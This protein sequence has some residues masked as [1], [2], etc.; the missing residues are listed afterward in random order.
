MPR[1]KK[2]MKEVEVLI[3]QYCRHVKKQWLK[4]SN[5]MYYHYRCFLGSSVKLSS[6]NFHTVFERIPNLSVGQWKRDA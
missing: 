1:K 5:E 4:Q 3:D 2:K 6:C